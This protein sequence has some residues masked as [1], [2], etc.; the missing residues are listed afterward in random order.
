MPRNAT[1]ELLAGIWRDLLGLE[2]VGIHDNFFS[3]GGD[4]IL[5]IQVVSRVSRAGMKLSVK[6]MFEY[7]TIEELARVV[8]KR[9]G[10]KSEQGMVRG[11]A[12]LT[13]IQRWWWEQEL[14]GKS[15]Y[16]QSVMLEASGE[17]EVGK[18]REVLRRIEEQHDALRMRYRKGEEGWEQELVEQEAGNTGMVEVDLEEVEGERKREMVERSAGEAQKSLDVEKGP[19]WRAVWMG[20]GG[21]RGRL[22][23]VAHH[24]VVDGVSWRILLED[25][26]RGYEQK[27]RGE[28]VRFG[29][30]TSSY[31]EWGEG[32]KRYAESEGVEKELEYWEKQLEGEG[33]EGEEE[34]VENRVGET[35]SIT[36]GLSEEE[37]RRLLQEVPEAYRTQINDVLLTA[38]GR[39]MKR[40]RGEKN[41]VGVMLEGHGR[42]DVVEGVDITRT[43]GWFTSLYPVRLE[44]EDGIGEGLKR[45]KEQLRRIPEKGMGY[46]LL[47][48]MN[49]KGR[50]R[51]GGKKEP[52][53]SFNYLGQLDQIL[54]E[55]GRFRGAK[56]WRGSTQDSRQ[57]RP[58][59]LE[60]NGS[61]KGGRLQLS[62]TYSRNKYERR[63][64]EDLTEGYID[65]LRLL[66][67]HCRSPHAGGFTP[68]DF[69]DANL[70]P[71]ALNSLLDH[72]TLSSTE[73]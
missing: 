42:E 63:T 55:K 17:M 66:I 59:H 54:E 18:V 21:G 46:G 33:G 37:T 36:V 41:G 22:L 53:V 69:P 11:K 52:E 34:G 5:S 61:V 48:Y 71:D 51:L 49:E 9:E 45:I 7:Q 24:L 67:D 64:V 4:S 16:N 3:A 56:E 14:E 27:E 39:A 25:L 43:V 57:K 1:E 73:E 10:V 70:E 13:P 28:E 60:I 47:R 65:E 38:L 19:V 40:W 68:S 26:Q 58:Y 20:L 62:W 32:L 30:K 8:E 12:P 2:T 23:L 6:Q 44:M 29:E 72:L 35:E 50:E 31:K 15:H